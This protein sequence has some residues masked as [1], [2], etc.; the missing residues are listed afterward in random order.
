MLIKRYLLFF[1]QVFISCWLSLWTVQAN[2]ISFLI[3]FIEKS[4]Q[5]IIFFAGEK[6]EERGLPNYEEGGKEGP[7]G[8]R[9]VARGAA[10]AEDGRA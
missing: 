2:Q 6:R 4:R 9:E 5:S 7:E 3:A 8:G 1:A 10:Q